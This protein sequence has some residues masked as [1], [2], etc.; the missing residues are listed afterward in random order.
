MKA[1]QEAFTAGESSTPTAANGPADAGTAQQ[2]PG[3]GTN[4]TTVSHLHAGVGSTEVVS[5]SAAAGTGLVVGGKEAANGKE[6]KAGEDW[7]QAIF[8]EEL[9][10]LDLSTKKQELLERLVVLQ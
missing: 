7:Y 6:R 4:I 5:A 10:L 1:W 2:T 9:A 8:E 3:G